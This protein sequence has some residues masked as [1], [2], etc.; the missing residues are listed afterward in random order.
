MPGFFWDT[1][2]LVKHYHPEP[3]T[4]RVDQLLQMPD[5]EHIISR[6]AVTETI[7]SNP[8]KRS[9]TWRRSGFDRSK[10]NRP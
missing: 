8:K 3:G 10:R 1:S 7:L 9:P 2:A 5:S 4:A 6:L